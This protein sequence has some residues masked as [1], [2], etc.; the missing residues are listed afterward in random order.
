[1]VSAGASVG[2]GSNFGTESDIYGSHWETISK[3]MEPEFEG[4]RET[5]I[6]VW[7]GCAEKV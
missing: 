5:N 7:L 2:C 3:G 1:M 6:I 4:A